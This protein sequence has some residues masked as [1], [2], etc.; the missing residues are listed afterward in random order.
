M[1]PN[2]WIQ[3][4][5]SREAANTPGMHA[6]GAGP[7]SDPLGSPGIFGAGPQAA[8]AIRTSQ[9]PVAAAWTAGARAL[10]IMANTEK[11]LP[12]KITNI[13]GKSPMMNTLGKYAASQL[14]WDF[15][16]GTHPG[17]G[18]ASFQ[19]MG[20][21]MGF[22]GSKYVQKYGW[23]ATL[24]SPM[25]M[26]SIIGSAVQL[27]FT[28]HAMYEGW[29]ENGI[30]GAAGALGEMMLFEAAMRKVATPIIRNSLMPSLSAIPGSVI[31]G[32][33]FAVGR[34][35]KGVAASRA[36][37]WG[38]R[39][40]GVGFGAVTGGLAAVGMALINPWAMAIAGGIYA[41]EQALEFYDDGN[42]A[43]ARQRMV[44]DLEM[45][46]P[47]MDQFGTIST[48]RQRSLS[49]IQNS[50]VNG[51]MALGNEAALLHRSF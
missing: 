43:I 13:T 23:E 30:T 24:K 3:D 47:V 12:D 8:A 25:R 32:K 35:T 17:T 41:V 33:E 36:G 2:A 18:K 29:K 40:A 10:D 26:A 15:G 42:R 7:P 51:R 5:L 50:H 45:G 21:S 20:D 37:Y 1:F 28:G 27:G 49:A 46:S 48:L 34:L 19:Y 9:T 31:A 11:Y 16:L 39:A 4:H 22:L 6:M 44:N 38:A 14:G